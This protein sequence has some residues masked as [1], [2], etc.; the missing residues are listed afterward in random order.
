[1]MTAGQPRR[2]CGACPESGTH[3]LLP[4]PEA[5]PGSRLTGQVQVV[6][7]IANDVGLAWLLTHV[8]WKPSLMLPPGAMV[9]L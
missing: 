2:R 9:P 1:M 7:L 6:P 4:G 8:P 5:G 3:A